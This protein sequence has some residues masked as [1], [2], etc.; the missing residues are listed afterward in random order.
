MELSLLHWFTLLLPLP[1]A[2][3][4]AAVAEVVVEDPAPTFTV[5]PLPLSPL[6]LVLVLLFELCL[7]A[8]DAMPLASD[9]GTDRRVSSADLAAMLWEGSDDMSIRLPIDRPLCVEMKEVCSQL[10]GKGYAHL[11]L[12]SLKNATAPSSEEKL[13]SRSLKAG[14]PVSSIK[15]LLTWISF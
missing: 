4:P 5:L 15:R 1:L 10:V 14:W 9:L 13:L 12:R 2:V 6:L 3:E 11:P 8:I 7:F